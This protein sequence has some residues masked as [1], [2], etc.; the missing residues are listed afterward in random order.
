[1]LRKCSGEWQKYIFNTKGKYKNVEL[2]DNI[3]NLKFA[4]KGH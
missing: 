1:M 3:L 4:L 2:V